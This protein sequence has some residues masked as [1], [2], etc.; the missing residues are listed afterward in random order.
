MARQLRNPTIQLVKESLFFFANTIFS[1]Q[2]YHEI[3]NFITK[4]Q[5]DVAHVQNV[6]SLISPSVYWALKK[7]GV[8]I[9][10]TVHNMRFL[11]PNSLFYTNHH[12]C[13]RCKDGNT[14]YAIRWKCYRQHYALSALYATTIG[15]HRRLG[16]FDII[17]TF[18]TPTEFTAHKL[19]E[20]RLADNITV[21][22]PELFPEAGSFERRNPY[23]TYI[24]RLSPEKGVT[25]L[26]EAMVGVP[27]V[28]LKIAGHGPQLPEL[29]AKVRSNGICSGTVWQLSF[30]QFAMKH[31][32]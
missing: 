14:L 19:E 23:L 6:F 18:I 2:T 5:L 16:T 25:I 24:G 21:L 31:L 29:N 1:R 10:Q 4:E 11:C 22:V 20:G 7:A 3:I 28:T 30:P 17:E 13:E 9:V 27:G 26:L 32:H 8:P 12:I 15:V